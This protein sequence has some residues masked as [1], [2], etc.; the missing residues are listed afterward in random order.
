MGYGLRL[1]CFV[2][3]SFGA[4][5]LLARGMS[6][7]PARVDDERPPVVQVQ[8][9]DPPPPEP[10][11]KPEPEP[12]PQHR[13]PLHRTPTQRS[14]RDPRIALRERANPTP[15]TE[16]PATTGETTKTPV[17]GIDLS[18]TSSG[19][20]GPVMPI[21]NTLQTKPDRK[22][23]KTAQGPIKP[24]EA[25]AQAYEVTKMPLPRGRCAGKYTE[26]A[27]QAGVEGTVVLDLIVGEDGKTRDIVVVAGLGHG[28]NEAAIAA[29][30]ACRFSPGERGGR[31]VPVRLRG[32]KIRFFLQ[33]AD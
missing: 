5:L 33:G 8:L 29:L 30:K 12:E 13:Q 17:F 24:L 11:R 7:L 16:R 1:T 6:R 14:P 3:V 25:P 28:L 9:R 15:P 32:F 18:S 10:E 26:Q 4:H 23:T 27:R 22:K 20:T 2:V 19:G 31:P 21:G